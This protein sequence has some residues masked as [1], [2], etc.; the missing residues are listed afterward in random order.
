M[1]RDRITPS[2]RGIARRSV[3]G[4]VAIEFF[5]TFQSAGVSFGARPNVKAAADDLADLLLMGYG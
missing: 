2:A 3:P 1:R 5:K 4:D